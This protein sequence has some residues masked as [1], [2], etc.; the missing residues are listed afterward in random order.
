MNFISQQPR[1]TPDCQG[2]APP[3]FG[4]KD[5]GN[6][7]FSQW[8]GPSRQNTVFVANQSDPCRLGSVCLANGKGPC[9]KY[10]RA[11]TGQRHT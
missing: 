3:R 10:M 7:M 1:C 4:H 9:R 5:T 6:G 8:E 2:D 11:G